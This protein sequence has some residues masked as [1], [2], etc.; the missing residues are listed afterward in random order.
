MN[1]DREEQ[2]DELLALNSIFDSDE[3]FRNESKFT[4]EIRVSVQLP[5][6]F[7]VAVKEGE[8][9]RQY[10]ISSL[11]PLC[12]TFELPEDYPTSSPPSFT[13]TCS[14]MTHSQLSALTAQLTDLYQ[15]TGGAVVLFIWI[16]FLKEDALK[17]L[18]IHSLLELPSDEQNNES[19][20]SAS[21]SGAEHLAG[22]LGKHRD[23]LILGETNEDAQEAEALDQNNSTSH[24]SKLSQN[25]LNSD[26]DEETPPTDSPQ[27]SSDEREADQTLEP[28]ELKSVSE[29][30]SS[31]QSDLINQEEVSNGASFLRSSSS[32]HLLDQSESAS[33]PV[34]PKEVPQTKYQTPSGLSLTLSQALLS[35]LLIH[36]AAQKQKE[37]NTTVFDCDICFDG[38]LGSEC[39]QL[40]ECGH[41]FCRGC[42]GKF[43]KLQITEGNVRGVTCPNADCPVTPTPVQVRSLVG[44]ELFKRYD[45]LLLQMSLDRMPDVVYCPRPTCAEAVVLD[46]SSRAAMCSVCNF[47]FCVACKKNYHGTED[48]QK[49]INI[50]KKMREERLEAPLP[51]SKRRIKALWADYSKGGEEKKKLLESR[52]GRNNLLLLLEDFLSEDWIVDN[53]KNCPHCFCRIEKNGGCNMMLCTQC[54]QPFC[55]ACLGRPP[56]SGAT[57]Y[58][59]HNC[60]YSSNQ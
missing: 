25:E 47:A 6:D 24:D 38:W 1:A 2:E 22:D 11:P 16:Q 50:V 10:E 43:C 17:F 13:L 36:N 41:I 34:R 18:D 52:Y 23:S 8:T 60:R 19:D 57:T 33:L 35:Q 5:P 49:K 21:S 28:S 39:V 27:I 54:R 59:N 7:T 46:K 4:G 29:Y 20:V 53:C 31:A 51:Q 37:F 9:Q 48:C 14:W 26:S 3:F 32:P 58:F 44:E 15:G 30:D 42:L 45:R 56:K 40:L 12:L 55:W